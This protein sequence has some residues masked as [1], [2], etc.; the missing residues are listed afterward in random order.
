MLNKIT[1]TNNLIANIILCKQ[2]REEMKKTAEEGRK[3]RCS[4]APRNVA[5]GLN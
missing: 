5:N 4:E 2:T 3:P 1:E